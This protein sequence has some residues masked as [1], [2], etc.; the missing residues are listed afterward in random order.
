M[1]AGD[2]ICPRCTSASAKKASSK[3]R[4]WQ[5]IAHEST[6]AAV[7]E[8]VVEES[9]VVALAEKRKAWVQKVLGKRG[10][11]KLLGKSGEDVLEDVRA[12]QMGARV[13]KEKGEGDEVGEDKV[14]RVM[15]VWGGELSDHSFYD[16]VNEVGNMDKVEDAMEID[17]QIEERVLSDIFPLSAERSTLPRLGD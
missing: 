13:G 7:F 2:W 14:E 4:K 9:R 11:V 6:E 10:E 3:S 12:R 15:D 5:R 16:M 17:R 1:P 8:D